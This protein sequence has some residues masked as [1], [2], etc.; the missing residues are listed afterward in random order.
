MLVES[1][2]GDLGRDPGPSLNPQFIH[3]HYKISVACA[4]CF[5]F[6]FPPTLGGTLIVY[7]ISRSLLPPAKWDKF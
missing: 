2:H 5:H 7:L 1:V 3:L 6:D 4:N